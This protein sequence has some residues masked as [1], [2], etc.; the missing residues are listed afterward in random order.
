MYELQVQKA[1][2]EENAKTFFLIYF[3]SL[4]NWVIALHAVKKIDS[5]YISALEMSIANLAV[6]TITAGE[7]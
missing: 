5:W 1:S 7:Y 6:V 2:L 3:F 4:H